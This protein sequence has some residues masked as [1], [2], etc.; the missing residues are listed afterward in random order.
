MAINYLEEIPKVISLLQS[1]G[2]GSNASEV[3]AAF[4]AASTSTELL[5]GVRFTLQQI[6][7]NKTSATTKQRI[8]ALIS[9]I[10]TILS[11]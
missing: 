10:D 9:V 3:Q 5:M 6:P 4:E 1:E 7:S 11:R 8:E 2:L